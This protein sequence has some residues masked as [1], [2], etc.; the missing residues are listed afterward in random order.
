MKTLSGMAATAALLFSG[1]AGAAPDKA[2]VKHVT[3][4]HISDTHAQLETHPEY[5]PGEKPDLTP[6][7][8]Y[9]RLKSA[10]DEQRKT[11]AGPSFLVDGGDTFQGT[12]A[13]AWSKGEAIVAPLNALD[14][15]LFVPGN[16][17]VVY[18]TA[19]FKKL[20]SELKAPVSAYNFQ[21]AGTGQRLFAPAV[22]VNR[23][24]V[25]VSFVGIT[26][27]TT[28][29]RQP[30]AVGVD[31]TH[32][33]GLREFVSNLRKTE[34]PDLV[35]AVTHT[36][37][38][39]SRDLA[40]QIPAF[41]VVLSGHTHERTFKPIFEGKVIVVEPGSMGS[42]VGRLD[43]TFGP[44]G[45]V[46]HSFRLVNVRASTYRED[47]AEKMLVE[48]ALAPF[49]ARMDHVAGRTK[50]PIMRYDV[51][52]TSADNFVAEAVR[53]A[54]HAD[55]G[56]TNGFRFTPPILPGPITEGQLW[57]LIPLDMP[58]RAGWVTGRDLRHYLERELELVYTADPWKLSGGW[59]PR[60]AGVT[61]T[62]EA[63][64][65]EGH[66]VRSLK[67]N[68][69]E[70][71]DDSH[72]TFSGCARPSDPPDTVC[73]LQAHEVRLVGMTIHQA[74]DAYLQEH[75]LVAPAVDGRERAVDLP[76]RVWS[77]DAVLHE[78]PAKSERARAN[79]I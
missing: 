24:G 40:R 8:G 47:P 63:F 37:L 53:E 66:R 13:A 22:T 42:F 27:P 26:D 36:G 30:Q 16:W 12:A 59:G 49:R 60:L 28:S 43:L 56:S 57:N 4:L 1:T 67:V 51:L 54:A 19:Q 18:G 58:L 3:L 76:A 61:F 72:Y 14:L 39:I 50:T 78:R 52:E 6:M 15:D 35:V 29:L 23:G 33:E 10:I 65:P 79:R 62:F 70:V 73:R 45:V 41:D 38:S 2:A 48:A 68:G 71:A 21:D 5:M 77:Q 64:G 17:E 20:M 31:T 75:P 32:L 55:I 34:H 11:A 9:A 74:L 46:S 44:R 25:R 69:N 7:G